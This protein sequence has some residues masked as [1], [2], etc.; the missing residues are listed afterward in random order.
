M[1][2]NLSRGL[3]FLLQ[4]SGSG[5]RSGFGTT[6]QRWQQP[7][8]AIRRGGQYSGLQGKYRFGRVDQET[9]D[10]WLE[11]GH[12]WKF[13]IKELEREGALGRGTDHLA[14]RRVY[15]RLRYHIPASKRHGYLP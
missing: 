12:C 11:A 3:S 7:D 13:G 5:P 14:Q 10:G 9:R 4:V 1:V 15:L 6:I 2:Y 8:V